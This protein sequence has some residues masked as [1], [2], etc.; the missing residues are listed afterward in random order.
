[1]GAADVLM[2]YLGSHVGAYWEKLEIMETRKKG[3]LIRKPPD[4]K[5][6]SGG[7]KRKR[8]L[9]DFIVWIDMGI[10]RGGKL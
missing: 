10:L 6:N 4:F 2:L 3:A 7:K 1:M 5:K 8:M 9:V